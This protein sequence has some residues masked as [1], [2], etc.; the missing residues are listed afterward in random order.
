[1][2]EIYQIFFTLTNE[3]YY[4]QKEKKELVFVIF[5]FCICSEPPE[6]IL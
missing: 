2:I 3:I 6:L 1:M 5:K 4:F